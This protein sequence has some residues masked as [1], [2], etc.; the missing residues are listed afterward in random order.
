M[1]LR[2][3][4]D[5]LVDNAL[6]HTPKAGL[7]RVSA[8]QAEQEVRIIVED[9]GP[10]F[11]DAFID[12]AFVPFTRASSGHGDHEGAG[13][14]LAIVKHILNRHRGELRRISPAQNSKDPVDR[15]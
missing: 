11:P 9:S 5:N 12:Q 10:G 7:V 15:R 3:A 2:Q 8:D 1:R 13:L 6:R 4:L 14:G